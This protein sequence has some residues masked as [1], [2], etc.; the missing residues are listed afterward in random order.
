LFPN[1]ALTPIIRSEALEANPELRELLDKLS[2]KL[3]DR[4]MQRLNERVD[5]ER[6]TVEAV[7]KDFLESEGLI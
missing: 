3:D 1:C 7:A 5:V 2:A 6:K 4:T